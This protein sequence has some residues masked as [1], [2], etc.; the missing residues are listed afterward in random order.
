MELELPQSHSISKVAKEN[1]RKMDLKGLENE[2]DNVLINSETIPFIL[3]KEE[4]Q[5]LVLIH[6]QKLVF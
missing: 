5:E 2:L 3:S 1:L 6:S 4:L